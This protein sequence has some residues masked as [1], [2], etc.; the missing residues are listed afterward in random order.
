[1]FDNCVSWVV[2]DARKPRGERGRRVCRCIPVC[3]FVRSGSLQVTLDIWRM[4]AVRVESV[5][6]G[7]EERRGWGKAVY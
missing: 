5:G 2:G 6:E 1:M 3:L 4:K 7:K